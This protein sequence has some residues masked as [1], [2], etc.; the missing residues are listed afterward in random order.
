M[1]L[2]QSFN[3]QVHCQRS[4][5]FCLSQTLFR[6]VP[7][8]SFYRC[9][10]ALPTPYKCIPPKIFFDRFQEKPS[11]IPKDLITFASLPTT[12]REFYFTGT[13]H[14]PL[15]SLP[16]KSCSQPTHTFM[17]ENFD[18]NLVRCQMAANAHTNSDIPN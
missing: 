10:H 8:R 7:L 17:Q 2:I 1:E 3:M 16:N 5:S 11:F 12:N 15:R 6:N 13:W 14:R 18:R 9:F 4:N